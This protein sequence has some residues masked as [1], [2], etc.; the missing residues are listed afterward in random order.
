MKDKKLF[1]ELPGN[2]KFHSCILTTFSF[3][4][5]HFEAQVMR[6]LKMKGISNISVFAD[7]RMLDQSIGLSTGNIKAIN[8]AYS[9]N[10]VFS[11]PEHFIQKITFCAGDKTNYGPVRIG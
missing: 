4:F 9:L 2:H 10:G 7:A 1:F 3:D 5:H 6:M 8:S 11:Q